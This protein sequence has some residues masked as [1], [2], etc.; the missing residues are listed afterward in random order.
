MASCH[1]HR[2]ETKPR[3]TEA[4]SDITKGRSHSYN[5]ILLSGFSD[6]NHHFP[7]KSGAFSTDW[8]DIEVLGSE[9]AECS[10]VAC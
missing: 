10:G 3:N 7:P 9:P 2:K 6:L 4:A 8:M 5:P 1:N